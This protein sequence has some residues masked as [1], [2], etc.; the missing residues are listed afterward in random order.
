MAFITLTLFVDD[1]IIERVK[2]E[3][4]GEGYDYSDE[5]WEDAEQAVIDAIR[6]DF[7]PAD[8]LDSEDG[9]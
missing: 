8:L 7:T 6:S 2:A 3:N 5:L 4:P 9:E 1:E